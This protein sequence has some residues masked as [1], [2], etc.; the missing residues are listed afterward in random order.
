MG[1]WRGLGEGGEG[2]GGEGGWGSD[3]VDF[4]AVAA[5][6]VDELAALLGTH[7]GAE[8][9]LTNAFA[10][11]DF[12]GVMHGLVRSQWSVVSCRGCRSQWS[13]VRGRDRWPAIGRSHF[14]ADAELAGLGFALAAA[15]FFG[16]FFVVGDALHI[17]DEAFLFAKFF[18][19]AQHLF[20]GFIAAGLDLDHANP[21]LLQARPTAPN[22]RF[23]RSAGGGEAK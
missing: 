2:G 7:A 9:H 8:A 3:G 1:G 11:G 10:I 14:E 13:V 20:G 22:P 21:S 18:E 15:A 6:A 12:V 4:A 17:L 19:A 23:S 5:F 16:R